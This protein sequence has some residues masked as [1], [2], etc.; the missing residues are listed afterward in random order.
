MKT[1][2]LQDI[3]AYLVPSS[4]TTQTEFSEESIRVLNKD[5]TVREFTM[6][7]DLTSRLNQGLAE[8]DLNLC[9][10]LDESPHLKLYRCC[11]FRSNDEFAVITSQFVE[12]KAKFSTGK[13]IVGFK[14]GKRYYTNL[15]NLSQEENELFRQIS[16]EFV[17]ELAE[18]P[19][20]RLF[21]V[22]GQINTEV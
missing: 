14:D 12:E 16:R 8:K 2:T 9:V 20:F 21:Y 13:S 6:L 11:F 5:Q 1:V 15:L 18:L 19:G 4:S 3:E 22:T 10:V 17:R 7:K